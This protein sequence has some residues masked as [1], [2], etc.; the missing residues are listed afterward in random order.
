M[1]SKRVVFS[2]CVRAADQIDMGGEFEGI[3]A[4]VA[5]LLQIERV[6]KHSLISG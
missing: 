2:L 6:K 4:I 5:E 3:L 1:A